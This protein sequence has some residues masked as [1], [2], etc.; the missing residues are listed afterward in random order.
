MSVC[1]LMTREYGH[2]QDGFRGHIQETV[3]RDL[4]PPS[5]IVRKVAVPVIRLSLL[6]IKGCSTKTNRSIRDTIRDM[7]MRE[8]DNAVGK[9]VSC[10]STVNY[11][12]LLAL[13]R[14]LRVGLPASR[15]RFADTGV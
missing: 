13:T 7:H 3:D 14:S 15:T 5:V 12:T 11:P 9:I 4:Q 2:D 6:C 10:C 1:D 8:F